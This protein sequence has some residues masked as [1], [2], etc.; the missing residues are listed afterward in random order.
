MIECRELYAL[1]NKEAPYVS[2]NSFLA[3][4]NH[5]DVMLTNL[6]QIPC[7]WDLDASPGQHFTVYSIAFQRWNHYS[8]KWASLIP[9]FQIQ[10]LLRG[11]LSCLCAH[12]ILYWANQN[13]A[14]IWVAS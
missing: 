5:Y 13:F 7:L 10:S 4:L 2:E 9:S 12:R 1:K 6:E 3:F 14:E 8:F 11:L